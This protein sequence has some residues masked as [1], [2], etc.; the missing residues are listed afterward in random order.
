MV[1]QSPYSY[2]RF[3]VSVASTTS[4]SST[5]DLKSWLRIDTADEDTEIAFIGMACQNMLEDLTNTTLM[6]QT[7]KV[8]FDGFPPEG[9]PMELPR[10]PHISVTAIKYVDDDGVQQTWDAAKYEVSTLGKLPIEILPIESETYPSTGSTPTASVFNKVE[11]EYVAGYA[12]AAEI[13]QGF[14]VGHRMF[15]GHFYNN[16]EAT[17]VDNVKDLPLG[18]QMI[19]ASNLIPEVN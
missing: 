14:V 5:A 7:M 9:T 10:P 19:V 1:Y 12:T 13:P 3:I 11:V 17:T 18:L 16:R 4:P 6:Q 2:E 8:Y 15:V